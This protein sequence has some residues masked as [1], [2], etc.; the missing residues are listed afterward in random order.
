MAMRLTRPRDCSGSPPLPRRS[1]QAQGQGQPESRQ[2]RARA[3]TISRPAHAG[4]VARRD[5]R[6]AR[7]LSRSSPRLTAEPER[8][9][10]SRAIALQMIV[11]RSRGDYGQPL[12]P[13]RVVV[14]NLVDQLSPVS[15]GNAGRRVAIS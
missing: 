14:K 8:S 13:H 10:G 2:R 12:R 5:G 9:A 11:S 7:K 3:G 1:G 6:W 4:G 15:A